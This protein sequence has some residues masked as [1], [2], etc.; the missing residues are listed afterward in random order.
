[1]WRARIVRAAGPW[2]AIIAYSEAASFTVTSN[3]AAW[4]SNQARSFSWFEAFVTVRKRSSRRYVKRSS[5]TPPS[6]LHS[7]EYCAPP[8]TIVVTSFD[9]IRWRNSSACGPVVSISPMC[10]TS[11]TP[12]CVRTAT[13]S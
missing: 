5:S 12:A 13:C 9:R 2:S 7:T 1:M 10:E 8:G 3:A 6:S 11:N 4:R